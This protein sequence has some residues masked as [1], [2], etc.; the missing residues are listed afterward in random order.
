MTR[1]RAFRIAIPLRRTAVGRRAAT[2]AAV[3]SARGPHGGGQSG[4]R[5]AGV[6]RGFREA[7]RG[8][9]HGAA[10]RDGARAAA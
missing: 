6:G 9:L 7:A 4:A 5:G 1:T 3:R 2:F 8:G 10:G